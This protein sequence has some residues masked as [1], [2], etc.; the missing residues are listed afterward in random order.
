MR[1][2]DAHRTQLATEASVAD[3][4]PQESVDEPGTEAAMTHGHPL[5]GTSVGIY[6]VR[7]RIGR[8]GM[9]E[10]Y[11]ARDTRLGRPVA[12]K[13]LPERFALDERFRGW[14]SQGGVAGCQFTRY[15][16]CATESCAEWLAR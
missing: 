2:A 13:V 7:T 3:V 10:V 5:E 1:R 15:L 6:D 9:G 14:R 12:L 11:L 16:F 4:T 8:G